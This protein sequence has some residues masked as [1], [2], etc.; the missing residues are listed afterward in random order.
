M[1]YDNWDSYG[2]LPLSNTKPVYRRCFED[3]KALKIGEYEVY[4]GS[5]S[6]PI[7]KDADV[8]IGFDSS[9][10]VS[11]RS[12]PWLESPTVEVYFHITDMQ[13]PADA[14]NFKDLIEW[15]ALQLIAGKKVHAGCIG[16]HGRTGTFLA[17]LVTHMTGEKDSIEY[18]RK[19]YCKKAVESNAQIEFLHKHY[20]ITKVDPSKSWPVKS[21]AALGVAYKSKPSA[22]K[23]ATSSPSQKTLPFSSSK[24]TQSVHG[25]GRSIT[26]VQSKRDV[27]AR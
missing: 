9:M 10:S 22:T 2:N 14:P 27:W 13:A 7:V 17:A 21:K 24:S 11:K 8:Y 23:A 6:F 4:G 3:H 25:S 1:S 20:G 26:P 12:W 16:G 5:C 18:V 15:A 19:N